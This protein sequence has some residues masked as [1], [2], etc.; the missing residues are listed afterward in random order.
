MSIKRGPLSKIEKF[1]VENNLG[2]T[3]A[4]LSNDLGRSVEQI[5]KFISKIPVKLKQE[6]EPEPTPLPT[7]QESAQTKTNMSFTQQIKH[8]NAPDKP[9]GTVMTPAGSDAGDRA[10]KG[11]KRKLPPSLVD[12]VTT[13]RPQG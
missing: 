6:P 12:C 2:K 3:S 1:Y 4:E 5:D 10:R 9:V 7:A 8:K 11:N 13:V